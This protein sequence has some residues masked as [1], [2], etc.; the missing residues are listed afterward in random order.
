MRRP[1]VIGFIIALL[2]SLSLP[3]YTADASTELTV[4][5]I[6]ANNKVYD[7][8]TSATLNTGSA[9][10]VVVMPG[11]DV[12]LDTSGATGTFADKNVGTAKMV[13]ISGLSLSGADAG[14]YSLT[15][16]TTTASITKKELTVT[17]ITA[18]NKAYDGTTSA[19]LN[20]GSAALSGV[21]PGDDVAL[22]ASGATGTFSDANV[23]TDKTV[24][25]SGLTISG[26]DASNYSLTQPTTTAS[27]TATVAFSSATYSVAENAGTASIMVNLSGASSQTITV[28]YATSNGSATAGSDYTAA[29]GPLT[30]NPGE[31]NKTFSITIT[32]DSMYEGAETVNLTLSSPSNATLGSPSTAVLTINDNESQPTVAFSSATYAVVENAGQA[33]ITVNLSVASTQTITVNY[34]TSD[35][36]ATAGSRYTAASGTL[37]FNP[38]NI[39]QTFSI[40]ITNDSVY[41]G[42]GTVNL[43]LSSPSN[44]TLGSP[45]TAVLTINDDEPK[46]SV[47]FSTDTYSVAENGGPVTITVNLSGASAQTITVNYTTSNGSA[48]AGSDYTTASGTLTFN[49]GETS[50]TFNISITVDAVYEGPET[51]NLALSSPSNATLGSP[52][53][54]VLTITDNQTRPIIAFSSDT[55][56]V[57]ENAGPATVTVYLTGASAQTITI[58]YATSDGTATAGSDYNAASGTLTFSP[59]TITQTFNVNIIEDTVVESSETVNLKL[60]NPSNATL[61]SPY[62]AVLTIT[63]NDTRPTVAFSSATYSVAENAG[64]ATITVNLSGASAQTITVNYTTS[65]GSATA[66]SDYIAASGT[67]TFSPGAVSKTFSITITDDSVYE[68]AET[69]YMLLSNPVNAP[70]GSPNTATLTITD[71]EIQPSNGGAETTPS[72]V[73][74]IPKPSPTVT[75]SPTA[76]PESTP[77]PSPTPPPPMDSEPIGNTDE[78]GVV[79]LA[80]NLTFNDG[81]ASIEI[82]EGTKALT[83]DDKPLETIQMLTITNPPSLPDNCELIGLAYDFQPNGA[84]FSPFITITLK[85]DPNSLTEGVSEKNICLAYVSMEDG[86]WHRLPSVVDPVNQSISAQ[87]SHFTVFAILADTTQQS[88][89][90]GIGWSLVGGLAGGLVLLGL[91][92][93]LY[94]GYFRE[95]RIKPRTE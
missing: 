37:T 53:T 11:D 92:V 84:I 38:G 13:T 86:L 39:T 61:G 69:V 57:A 70:L 89:T 74:T 12:A 30:F 48:T 4:T 3:V 47:A 90:S 65:D 73:T 7:G 68:G 32:D 23:G 66:G 67:L 21:V 52:S 59:G 6:T 75:P 54:A 26:A 31:T 63:D 10:L 27:I 51:V 42:A 22:D 15:Q 18:N 20:T 14:N 83:F 88:S 64:P 72:P 29:S 36:S 41:E 2:L 45:S 17:G 71:N 46:P 91:A 49:S 87:A 24:T 19:T 50:K 33:N 93:V 43:T 16:P 9:A 5:G 76:K 56:S 40:T 79:T 94:L 80:Q 25:I 58:D 62:T 85:Y 35:G 77:T 81:E 95:H 60:M 82:A 28:N 55:Y 44:A 8:N 78:N 1:I 34:A